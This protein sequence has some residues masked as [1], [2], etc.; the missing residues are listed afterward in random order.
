[1]T[2]DRRQ[3][4][5]PHQNGTLDSIKAFQIYRL[6]RETRRDAKHQLGSS[7]Y[8]VHGS[9]INESTHAGCPCEALLQ[10]ARRLAKGSEA[11]RLQPLLNLVHGITVTPAASVRLSLFH[12][13]RFPTPGRRGGGHKEGSDL[14][15]SLLPRWRNRKR[16]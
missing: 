6:K 16:N 11:L 8:L 5:W 12:D 7:I 2:F 15:L 3:G 14:L 4:L 10:Y 9:N 1:M 13:T